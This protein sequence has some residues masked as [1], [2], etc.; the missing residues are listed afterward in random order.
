VGGDES[1]VGAMRIGMVK[2]LVAFG[3]LVGGLVALPESANAATSTPVRSTPIGSSP[4]G[5]LLAALADPKAPRQDY[6]GASVAVSGTTAIVGAIGTHRLAGAAYIFIKG[7][8]GWPSKPTVTLKNPGP[9]A[10][11]FG[12]SVALSG[13]TAIVGA[14]ATSGDSGAAY[15]YVNGGSGW[16]TTPTVTLADPAATAQDLFGSSVAVSGDTAM[17]GAPKDTSPYTGTAY[18][19]VNGGSGWPTTPTVTLA[20]PAGPAYDS[21][22]YSVAVS[23]T[24]AAVGAVGTDSGAGAAYIYTTGGTSV[25]QT[26]PTATLADPA[27]TARDQFG[28]SVAIS[29]KETSVIVGAPGSKG[30]DGTA[31]IYTTS[32]SSAWPTTPTTTLADPGKIA[33]FGYSVVM[34]ERTILVGAT[35]DDG[36]H[37][38]ALIYVKGASGWPRKPTVTLADPPNPSQAEFGNSVALSGTTAIIGAYFAYSDS[39]RAYIYEA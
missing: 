22:G 10:G 35:G 34:S 28:F 23:A 19:Y 39:G 33:V 9:T 29:P 37:G 27:A 30:D 20:D 1:E 24:T 2:F 25:W 38:N 5:E 14:A 32:G 16:P 17:V 8:S 15:I 31:Y 18:I 4:I 7:A 13:N 36:G 3:L 12:D 26:T 21:F 6:F 11:E